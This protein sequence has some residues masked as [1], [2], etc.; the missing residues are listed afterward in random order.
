M[1]LTKVIL[2]IAAVFALTAVGYFMHH[3]W[4]V[5]NA[6][7][8]WGNLASLAGAKEQ[9]AIE[10]NAA[11]GAPVTSDNI[12]PYVRGSRMPTCNVV[13]AKYILGKIGEEPRCTI[14]GTISHYKPDRM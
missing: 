10:N 7:P 8:C 12:L 1:K 5:R 13:N 11:L 9:W 3:A 14:H 6:Q 4:G 2:L